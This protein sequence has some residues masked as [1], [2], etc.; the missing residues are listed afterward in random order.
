[1]THARYHG[2]AP[3]NFASLK[4]IRLLATSKRYPP[5]KAFLK[6]LLS[7]S[8][9]AVIRQHR[10]GFRAWCRRVVILFWAGMFLRA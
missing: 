10:Q 2:W 8:T 4:A 1:M 3:L 9:T 6:Y 7:P 5:F